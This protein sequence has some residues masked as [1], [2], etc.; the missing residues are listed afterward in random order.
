[1]MILVLDPRWPDLIP[2]QAI[3]RILAPVEFSPEVPVTVRWNFDNL[4]CGDDPTGEGTL[5]TTDPDAVGD[6]PSD[7]IR[8]SSLADS[9]FVAR[10]VMSK[11]RSLG[12]WEAAQTHESLLP[13]LREESEEFA[14]AV[15][16][17]ASEE[18]LKKELGDV[19]LQVLFHAEIA[20]RRG[21]FGIDEVAESFVDK[22]RSRAPYLFD[23]TSRQVSVEE[24]ERLW[25]QGKRAERAR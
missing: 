11:A 19:F 10:R 17:G 2:Q 6:D 16:T 12:E 20:S 23:G 3:G 15:R 4:V 9:V 13:Y 8:A 21:G 22:L 14:E 1:M 5:V 25:E 7:V 18:E 24:Q